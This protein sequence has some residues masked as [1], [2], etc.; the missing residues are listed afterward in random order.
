MAVPLKKLTCPVT[1]SASAKMRNTVLQAESDSK[2]EKLCEAL[3][4]GKEK[5]ASNVPTI[6]L[7]LIFVLMI[8]GNVAAEV[9]RQWRASK[10]GA[11]GKSPN[12]AEAGIAGNL[13]TAKSKTKSQNKVSWSSVR[14]Y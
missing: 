11:D 12:D 5:T 3:L 13:K 1:I 9:L 4:E 14:Q 2:C 8:G 6:I 10:S 7:S